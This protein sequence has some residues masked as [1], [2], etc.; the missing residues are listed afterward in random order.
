MLLAGKRLVAVTIPDN[1]LIAVA[2]RF[3]VA[4]LVELVSEFL[5][6]DGKLAMAGE[7]NRSL[8]PP[9]G[10]DFIKEVLPCVGPDAGFCLHAP[11]ASDK[12]WKAHRVTAR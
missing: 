3:D 1:A 8:G 7:L 10:K 2:G 11:T 12:G 4:A 5:P 9:L 6:G